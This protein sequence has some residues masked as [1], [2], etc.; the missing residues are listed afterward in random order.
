MDGEGNIPITNICYLIP[1]FPDIILFQFL[2]KL[3]PPYVF[4]RDC[5]FFG[6]KELD[7]N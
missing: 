4:D 6:G 7:R 2:I 5:L 1:I 3:N